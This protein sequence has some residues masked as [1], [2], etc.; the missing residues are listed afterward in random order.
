MQNDAD[1]Q[2][3]KLKALAKDQKEYKVFEFVN[4]EILK[5]TQTMPI[6]FSIQ[7][8]YMRER[9]W[10]ELK[11][12]VK[13]DFD[14]TSED[15]NLEFIFK[16][17]LP[18]YEEKIS[19]LTDRARKQLAIEKGLKEIAELWNVSEKS[20]LDIRMDKSKADNLEYHFVFSTDTI[21][22]MIEE[23]G[24]ELGKFKSSPYYK[25]F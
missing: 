19:E 25:E 17:N 9:H 11:F 16:L 8:P 5:F 2:L 20:N 21:M 10:K 15:F 14:E 4:N 13:D 24:G 23:H 12:E 7:Q 1:D 22:A 3:S 18:E 6:I